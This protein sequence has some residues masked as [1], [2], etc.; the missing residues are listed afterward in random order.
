MH[1]KEPTYCCQIT[2]GWVI[3]SRHVGSEARFINSSHE[4]NVVLETWYVRNT[5][6]IVVRTLRDMAAVEELLT[7]Y[8]F[9]PEDQE[10]CYCGSDHCT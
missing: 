5:P 3:D 9:D 2:A 8:C 1:Q 7:E 4:P 10:A 6:H